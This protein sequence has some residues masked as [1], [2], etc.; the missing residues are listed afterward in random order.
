VRKDYIFD[1]LETDDESNFVKL[2]LEKN[3]W[4][5]VGSLYRPTNNNAENFDQL[6]MTTE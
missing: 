6:S 1:R 2:N 5:I 3:T 4:L